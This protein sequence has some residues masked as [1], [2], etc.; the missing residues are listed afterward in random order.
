M[1]I[2]KHFEEIFDLFIFVII[3]YFRYILDITQI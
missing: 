3:T 1:G 2:H